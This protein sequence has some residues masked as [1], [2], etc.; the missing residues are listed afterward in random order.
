MESFV[1][2]IYERVNRVSLT[3]AA[4]ALDLSDGSERADYVNQDYILWGM[5]RPHRN[6][7]IM[8]TYYPLDKEWPARASEVNTDPNVKSAWGYCYD[9]Y[10]TYGGGIGGSKDADVFEQMRDIR[11]HG[12]DVTLTLTIDCAVGDE[13]LIAIAKDLSTFGRIR[14]RINHECTGT[15]FAHNQRYTVKQISE[16]FVRFNA[17]LKKHAPNVK[18]ILCAGFVNGDGEME[19]EDDL[20]PAYKAA[21][22]WSGDRYLALH[23]GWPFD[24]CEKDVPSYVINPV[25]KFYDTVNAT[26]DRLRKITGQDKPFVASEMNIDGD[27][28]GP[29]R[30]GEGIRILADMLKEHDERKLTS[31]TMYQFRDEGRLGLEISDPN[32]RSVGIR[33]PLYDCYKKI[34]HEDYFK[35]GVEAGKELAITGKGSFR[36]PVK[37]RWGGAEDASGIALRL[38]L[39]KTPVFMDMSFEE[40]LSLMIC[41][42]DRWFYKAP[43]TKVIDLMPAFFDA[44]QPEV[45]AGEEIDILLFSTPPEGENEPG[46][47]DY[48]TTMKQLPKLHL[49]YEPV[50]RM[51]KYKVYR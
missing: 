30:Q 16:F 37:L 19:Y 2:D 47:V 29:V 13:H 38:K 27:V 7:N 41:V 12:Q 31:F 28:T 36:Q 21:D 1:N 33:Q 4:C 10:P 43:G 40:E 35:P 34:I 18:T 32:N 8:F 45:K 22:I 24:V 5:G 42:N 15:W 3:P 44:G 20:L 17:I 6:I 23:F 39:E 26:V 25:V 14:L 46:A 11:K 9:D 50:A 49:R 51:T 48:E